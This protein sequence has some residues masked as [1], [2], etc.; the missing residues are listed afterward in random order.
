MTEGPKVV[1]KWIPESPS[2][3]GLYA[4][5]SPASVGKLGEGRLY[6]TYSAHSA[7]QFDEKENCRKWCDD[8]N[9]SAKAEGHL[10]MFEPVLHEFEV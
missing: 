4:L 7:L 8:W 10:G 1:D 3:P 2:I 5:P 6:G 9:A